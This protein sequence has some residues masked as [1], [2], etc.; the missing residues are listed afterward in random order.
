MTEK[1]FSIEWHSILRDVLRNWWVIFCAAVIGILGTY[2][3]KHVIYHPEYTSRATVIVNSAAGKA[4]AVATLSDSEKIAKIYEEVFIQPSMKKKVCEYLKADGFDGEISARVNEG[5]NIM[6]LSVTASDPEEAYREL[7]AVLKVY[8]QITS[9]LYANGVVSV[10]R[11]ASVPKAPSNNMTSASAIKIALISMAIALALIVLL[12]V[13]RD[14]VKDER[15]FNEKIDANLLGTIPHERK[16]YRLKD[17]LKGNKKG[18]L[19][20]ESIFTSLKFTENYNKIAGKLEYL[21]RTQGQKVFAVASVAE[22]EGKSTIASNLA[23]ALALKGGRVVLLDLDCKK[24]ALFKIF[25]QTPD[26]RS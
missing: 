4:N 6:E 24:P 26:E 23:V 13:V 9:T 11:P 16:F 22:N 14:T 20:S 25:Q 21:Q 10:L 19:F 18:I 8:P 5:T 7:T 3:V 2:I 15:T 12:S 1:K 17:A